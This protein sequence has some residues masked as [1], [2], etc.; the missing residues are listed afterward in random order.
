[1]T[2][3]NLNHNNELSQ[4][5]FSS[6]FPG[7]L[8]W[9][10]LQTYGSESPYLPQLKMEMLLLKER[11]GPKAPSLQRLFFPQPFDNSL[12]PGAQFKN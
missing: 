8:A 7:T 10:T 5:L 12:S 9:L 2:Q 3:E 11:R 4:F 1:M 6:E